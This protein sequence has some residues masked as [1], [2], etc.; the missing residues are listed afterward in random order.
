MPWTYVS[1]Q[2]GLGLIV[3]SSRQ[4]NGVPP[5]EACGFKSQQWRFEGVERV[6]L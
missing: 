4:L 5:S 2:R 6:R 3:A 1:R